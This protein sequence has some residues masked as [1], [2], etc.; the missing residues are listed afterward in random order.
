MGFPTP[1]RRTGPFFFAW[2]FL[3]ADA[4]LVLSRVPVFGVGSAASAGAGRSSFCTSKSRYETTIPTVQSSPQAAARIFEPQCEQKRARSAAQP[5]PRGP[6]APHAR[7]T[8]RRMRAR[9]SRSLKFP[10]AAR[11]KTGR[12]FSRLRQKGARLACGCLVANWEVLPAGDLSRLGVITSSKLG[13]A[14]V[15]NRARRLMR[16][17]FRRHQHDLPS[18]VNLV[19]VA[20]RSIIGKDFGSV[21]RDYMTALRRARL[22]PREKEP[23][24]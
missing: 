4:G 20:R 7:L 13:N 9:A 5:P 10:R 15:R 22:L 16:E 11:L 18:P 8:R 3:T 19:L 23:A 1:S 14:V 24:P 6:Q 2:D 12:D 21:E 17:A